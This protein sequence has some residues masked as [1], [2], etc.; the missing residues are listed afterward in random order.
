M[1]DSECPSDLETAETAADSLARFSV[2]RDLTEEAI[3]QL[4]EV[5]FSQLQS[6][7]LRL[8]QKAAGP[9]TAA[10]LRLA[11]GTGP[12][13]QTR[14]TDLAQLALEVA[15]K[16]D[17][18]EGLKRGLCAEAEILL[19]EG[20]RRRRELRKAEKAFERAAR[21]PDLRSLVK[22]GIE[23]LSR[24]EE[25]SGELQASLLGFCIAVEKGTATAAFAGALRENFRRSRNTSSRPGAVEPTRKARRRHGH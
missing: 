3:V 4:G 5:P 12:F 9:V 25:I 1:S 13:N 20:W 21:E 11:R 10:L 18:P 22:E 24:C 8:A 6:I 14:K 15:E 19:G 7:V 16:G 2:L 23:P 17:M